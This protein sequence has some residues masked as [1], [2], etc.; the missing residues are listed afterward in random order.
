[1]LHAAPPV[2]MWSLRRNFNGHHHLLVTRAANDRTMYG[3]R[4]SGLRRER[5]LGCLAR[6]DHRFRKSDLRGFD[7][8]NPFGR[9]KPQRRRLSDT[10]LDRCRRERP[11]LHG[12]VDR[13]GRRGQDRAGE[14]RSRGKTDDRKRTGAKR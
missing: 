6:D 7:A 5:Y 12:N 4:S 14:D 3:K 2:L 10:S 1:M 9:R 11:V 13:W 8:V